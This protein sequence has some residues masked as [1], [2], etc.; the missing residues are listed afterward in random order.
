MCVCPA[1]ENSPS[2][3]PNLCALFSINVVSQFKKR[4]KNKGAGERRT[5]TSRV[6]SAQTLSRGVCRLIL[7]SQWP[8][9]GG[10]SPLAHGDKTEFWEEFYENCNDSEIFP[11][12]LRVKSESDQT[13]GN[14]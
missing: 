6:F 2:S 1:R 13:N 7:P 4:T 9:V 14:S 11:L 3:A 10:V 12:K 8:R 5:G